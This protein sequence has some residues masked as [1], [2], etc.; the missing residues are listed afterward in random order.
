MLNNEKAL[1]FK[2]LLQRCTPADS[3]CR[4]VK[5]IL[6]NKLNFSLSA[7]LN[8]LKIYIGIT[9]SNSLFVLGQR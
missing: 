4:W 9:N 8:K 1:G 5:S 3:K 7:I 6:N 2:N